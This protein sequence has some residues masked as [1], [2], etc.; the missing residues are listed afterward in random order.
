[1]ERFFLGPDRVASSIAANNADGFF[2]DMLS[3]LRRRAFWCVI[4]LHGDSGP[5]SNTAKEA[6]EP[7]LAFEKPCLVVFERITRFLG[8]CDF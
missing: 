4:T 8:A 7:R 5:T 1:V 6:N 2:C 3:Q